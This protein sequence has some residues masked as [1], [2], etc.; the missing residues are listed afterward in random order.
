MELAGRVAKEFSA[1][2]N[3]RSLPIL[4]ACGTGWA[5]GRFRCTAETKLETTRQQRTSQPASPRPGGTVV[6]Y[7]RD[8]RLGKCNFFLY[9]ECVAI[10]PALGQVLISIDYETPPIYYISPISANTPTFSAVQSLYVYGDIIDHRRVG[11]ESAQLMDI[12]P[13]QGAPGQ[14]ADYVLSDGRCA[15]P[16]ILRWDTERCRTWRCPTRSA[17]VP[18]TYSIEGTRLVRRPYTTGHTSWQDTGRS[19]KGGTWSATRCNG[20]TCC[21]GRVAVYERVYSRCGTATVTAAAGGEA[22]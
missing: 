14:R 7:G 5:G 13:V 10:S 22:A 6:V 21:T 9:A 2:P 11:N 3:I 15:A 1:V 12:A 16:R 8:S 17:Q 19:C 18:C 20:R 4:N